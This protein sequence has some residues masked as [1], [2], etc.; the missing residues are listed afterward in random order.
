MFWSIISIRVL[1]LTFLSRHR[2]LNLKDLSLEFILSHLEEPEIIRGLERLKAE[3]DLLVEIIKRNT[4]ASIGSSST[5]EY[6]FGRSSEWSGT[7]R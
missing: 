5:S 1:T 3:P 4:L 2:A 7:G 6:P